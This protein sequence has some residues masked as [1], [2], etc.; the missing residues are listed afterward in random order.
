MIVVERKVILNYFLIIILAVFTSS[1][2]V[3]NCVEDM[4]YNYDR[5]GRPIKGKS[6][7]DPPLFLMARCPIKN[8]NTAKIHCHGNGKYRGSAWWQNQNPHMGEGAPMNRDK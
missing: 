7:I 1:C 8:C 4:A 5:R 2:I 6:K 3:P